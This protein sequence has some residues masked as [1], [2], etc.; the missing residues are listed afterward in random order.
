[1]VAHEQERVSE[2]AI[3][4]PD[5]LLDAIAARLER[6]RWAHVE[7]VATYLGCYVRR[8]RDLRER[9]LPAR[10]IGKKLVF[11]LREVDE[12]IERKGVRV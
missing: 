5:D 10:R 8:V 7:A 1:L 2:P 12:W 11:D 4:I 3:P 6:Q 9:G